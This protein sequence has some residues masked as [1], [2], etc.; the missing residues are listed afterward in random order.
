MYPHYHRILFRDTER[1]QGKIDQLTFQI[2][3]LTKYHDYL[4]QKTNKSKQTL[5]F[6]YCIVRAETDKIKRL[7]LA[8]EEL[9]LQIGNLNLT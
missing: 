6:L 9:T 5:K 8:I 3:E 1:I 7:E 4:R 2:L